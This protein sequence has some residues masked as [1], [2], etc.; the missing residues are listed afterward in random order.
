MGHYFKIL[1]LGIIVL[2]FFPSC[3]DQEP[4]I[5]IPDVTILAS[6]PAVEKTSSG[7]ILFNKVPFSGNIQL[8]YDIGSAQQVT[9]YYLG[10]KQGLEVGYYSNGQMMFSR[11]YSQGEKN[12]IHYGWH[13]NGQMKFEYLF[14]NG[15]SEGN[16][17]EWYADGSQYKDLNYK[18]GHSFSYQKIWR[19]DGK[20]RSNYVIK[21]NGRKYGLVGLKRCSNIDTKKEKFNKI[22]EPTIQ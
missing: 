3:K 13:E 19:S 21:E 1:F 8:K 2:S 4:E 7:L 11:L 15:L 17:K 12:G 6:D 16:H 14:V 22:T 9:Q 18:N 20:I 5:V 10:K